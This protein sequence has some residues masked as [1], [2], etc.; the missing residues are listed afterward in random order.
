MNLMLS[1]RV[2]D[3]FR[4][5]VDGKADVRNIGGTRRRLYDVVGQ[6]LTGGQQLL[7]VD[8]VVAIEHS[9]RFYGA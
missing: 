6:T 4:H 7:L 2:H 9:P 3:G 1:A 8:D 5:I